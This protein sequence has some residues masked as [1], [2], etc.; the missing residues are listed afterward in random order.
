MT[1]IHL[2][3]ALA[4]EFAPTLVKRITGS[5]KAAEVIAD[6]VDVAENV[7]GKQGTGALD[8]LRADPAL[9]LQFQEHA[10][11]LEQ[12]YLADTQDARR[13]DVALAQA[14]AHN[15][16]ANVMAAAALFIVIICLAIVVW[17]S[18]LDEFAKGAVTLILGR[19]L[20]WVEQIFSFEFGTTRTSKAKDDTINKLSK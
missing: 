5:D 3:L 14:G 8:A 9:V 11:R 4:A 16:R 6:V 13:R 7:T 1:P 20:G 19:A 10:G 2:A 12:Q 17:K 15:Y 18:G